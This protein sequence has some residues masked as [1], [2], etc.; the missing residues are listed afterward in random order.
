VCVCVCMCACV[1]LHVCVCAWA[2]FCACLCLCVV[3]CLL[4]RELRGVADAAA[5]TPTINITY[6]TPE[7]A[8]KSVLGAV[9]D[10]L[11]TTAQKNKIEIEGMAL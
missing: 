8:R 4:A 11:M 1:C 3:V 2:C 5:T 6:I 10:N 7:D 9:G